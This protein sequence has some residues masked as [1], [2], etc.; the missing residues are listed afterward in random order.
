[1]PLLEITTNTT[2]ENIHDFAARASALTAEM[3]SKP[4]GYVMVKIQQEQT[5]LF[6]GDTA[7]AAHVKLKSLG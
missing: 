5:L 1:M 6:A 7:P 4:E 3:L 2:I